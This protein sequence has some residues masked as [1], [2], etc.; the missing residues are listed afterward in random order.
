VAPAF[1]RRR[2][3]RDGGT[4]KAEGQFSGV[5]SWIFLAPEYPPAI[6]GIAD[7]LEQLGAG[8]VR[9]GDEVEMVAP[10]PATAAPRSGVSVRELLRGYDLRA[11]REITARARAKPGVVTVL[12]YIPMAFLHPRSLS[13]LLRWPGPLWVMFHE[14]AYPFEAGQRLRHRVLAVG[15]HVAARALAERAERVLVSTPGC[16]GA[17]TKFLPGA[18]AA[19]WSPI[20]SNLARGPAPRA[21][22]AVLAGFGLDPARPVVGHFS[23]FGERVAET[24]RNTLLRLF[25]ADPS[26]QALLVGQGSEAF[27]ERLA[28][29]MPAAAA[30]SRAGGRVA[31][32]LAGEAIDAS[33]VLLFPY[34]DGIS[35]RRTTAM[36]GLA[37]G[38]ALVTNDGPNTES[39]WR[40]EGCVELCPHD[41]AALARGL[42]A[43]LADAPRRALLGARA[44]RVYEERFAVERVVAALRELRRN[45]R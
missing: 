5:N 22:E 4:L 20:P 44:A 33:D 3:G 12:E 6:G 11:W 41:P 45:D 8:L 25:Q 35:T 43:L 16:E 38:K 21:R 23:A 27:A 17:L 34:P 28:R 18:P 2:P 7:Y 10:A 9:A 19:V 42:Q 14:S 15:T 13:F 29:E 31:S 32:E 30:R 26:V 40:R 1:A 36:A 24:L 37:F 39:L